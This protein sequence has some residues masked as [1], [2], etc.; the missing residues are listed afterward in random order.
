MLG[1]SVADPHAQRSSNAKVRGDG[2]AIPG[3]ILRIDSH[4]GWIS[5]AANAEL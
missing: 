2:C 4:L 3:G 5:P 1:A